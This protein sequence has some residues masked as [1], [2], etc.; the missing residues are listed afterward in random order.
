MMYGSKK[1]ENVEPSPLLVGYVQLISPKL[2]HTIPQKGYIPV[3]PI[4]G[5]REATIKVKF[6]AQAPCYVYLCL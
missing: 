1:G 5:E 6:K 3:C 2:Q 4:F